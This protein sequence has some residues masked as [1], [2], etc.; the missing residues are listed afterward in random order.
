MLVF[1]DV[2]S[3]R[4]FHEGK[5]Q[6][7][8]FHDAKMWVHVHVSTPCSSG[9]PLKNFS[10][11][12]QPMLGDL[13]WESIIGSVGRYM[14]LAIQSLLNSHFQIRFG[15]DLRRLNCYDHTN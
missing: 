13:E 9:S 2:Q 14:S 6:V 8:R 12:N 7:K 15:H 11:D 10:A 4:M 3:D 5:R 1:K